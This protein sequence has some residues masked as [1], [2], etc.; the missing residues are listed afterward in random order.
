LES[1]YWRSARIESRGNRPG[2]APRRHFKLSREQK[3]TGLWIKVEDAHYAVPGEEDGRP[4]VSATATVG[5]RNKADFRSG[6]RCDVIAV[7]IME[8]ITRRAII[9]SSS[10]E[11]DA[12]GV[13]WRSRATK[14]GPTYRNECDDRVRGRRSPRDRPEDGAGG[15]GLDI[16][17]PNRQADQFVASSWCIAKIETFEDS[18]PRVE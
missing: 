7:K 3:D 9:E 14:P 6:C 15:R 16:N 18:D 5:P 4:D 10:C 8:F 11:G 1:S 17:E 13:E 2:G 12:M